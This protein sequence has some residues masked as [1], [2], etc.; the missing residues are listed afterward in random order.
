VPDPDLANA[1]RLTFEYASTAAGTA[2]AATREQFPGIDDL[3]LSDRTFWAINKT[4]WPA[5]GHNR[6]P[7]PL[8][9]LETGRTYVFELFNASK[10]FHPI[11]IHGHTF[12]VL[13]STKQDLPRHLA[14][15]VLLVPRERLEVAFVA[16]NPGDWMFHCHLIEHQETGMMGYVRVA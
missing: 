5:D 15:T 6:L 16:D 1:T 13:S 4:S 3:C 2:L 7:P 14:D 12:T 8:A 10:Q 11:H 9:L